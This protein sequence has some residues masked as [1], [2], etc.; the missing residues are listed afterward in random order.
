MGV[1]GRGGEAGGDDEGQGLEEDAPWRTLSSG[2]AKARQQ[3]GVHRRRAAA[4]EA[5]GRGRHTVY[6]PGGLRRE[7]LYKSQFT[8]VVVRKQFSPR[9]RLA[10]TRQ[11]AGGSFTRS[12]ESRDYRPV[13]KSFYRIRI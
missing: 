3:V 10:S 7:A 13:S 5:C 4:R 9:F 1:G 12:I 2:E 11:I 6:G 8:R